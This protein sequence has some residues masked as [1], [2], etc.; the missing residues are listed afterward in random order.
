VIEKEISLFSDDDM[1]SET[2]DIRKQFASLK[3]GQPSVIRLRNGKVLAVCWAFEN[4]QHVIKGYF[5][6]L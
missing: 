4:C 3:F 6:E 1:A 5:V 2:K